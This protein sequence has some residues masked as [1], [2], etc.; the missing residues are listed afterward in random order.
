MGDYIQATAPGSPVPVI[1]FAAFRN[2]ASQNQRKETA[3]AIVQ[4]FRTVGFV[5]LL[6]H[7]IP[8]EKVAECYEWS[9]KF[10]GL[11]AEEKQ[12]CLRIH[13]PT[14]PYHRG[15][16]GASK[17]GPVVREALE[18]SRDDIP[19]FPNLWPSPELMPGFHEFCLDYFWLCY[20]TQLEILHAIALG[21]DIK[22][23]YFDSYHT[24]AVNQLRF[25]YYPSIEESALRNGEQERLDAHTDIRTLTMLL[26][27]EVGGLE[28]EDPNERGVYRPSPP[29]KGAMIV[30]IG[31]LLARWSN[32][33]L[34]S[35]MHRVRAP[36]L[37]V[38]ETDKERATPPR[39]SIP[40]FAT[41]N[42]DAVIDT[43]P[44]T[45]DDTRPK[46]YEPINTEAYIAM[47]VNNKY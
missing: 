6:N 8:Q 25:L 35:P 14:G 31:D 26:Q 32:D 47:T 38:T 12:K 40:Y 9:K 22:E 44:G 2:P 23:D 17:N 43:L 21:L 3:D 1:D 16:S 27:D 39:Y 41:P 46:K 11:P 37:R 18:M 20:K 34:H 13:P 24:E 4:A 36:P 29:V 28:V 30:N 10:F 7:G 45:W 5:Y 15:W 33:I 19:E 42:L